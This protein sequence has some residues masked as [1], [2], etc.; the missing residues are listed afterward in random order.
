MFPKSRWRVRV[1]VRGLMVPVVALSAMAGAGYLAYHT[2]T[3]ADARVT[4]ILEEPSVLVRLKRAEDSNQPTQ[5]RKIESPLVAQAQALAKHID[6][7]P[8]PQPKTATPRPPVRRPPLR[9]RPVARP[10]V[11]TPK[12]RL[13]AT[14]CYPSDPNL[15]MALIKE[16]GGTQRWVKPGDRVGHLVIETVHKQYLTYRDGA[17]NG[18]L[19]LDKDKKSH[20]PRSRALAKLV[21]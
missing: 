9:P 19:D 11:S 10:P 21:K 16:A 13:M 8:A 1:W 14:G 5:H 3:K 7:P 17:R 12:F 6:P 4:A 20:R 15:S 2:N 18:K